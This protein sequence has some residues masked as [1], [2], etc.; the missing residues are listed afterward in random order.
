MHNR[1]D[2]LV[3][4][5]EFL[6]GVEAAFVRTY[7]SDNIE[8]LHDRTWHPDDLSVHFSVIVESIGAYSSTI[9]RDRAIEKK[10]EE[11]AL[12]PEFQDREARKIRKKGSR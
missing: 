12:D 6:A 1:P 9:I 5:A 10:Y 4:P 2:H 8:K 3:S 11:L 7:L